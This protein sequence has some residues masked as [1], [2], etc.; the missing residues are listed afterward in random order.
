MFTYFIP[1]T[2]NLTKNSKLEKVVHELNAL[3][4]LSGSSMG[5]LRELVTV[6]GISHNFLIRTY[7][8]LLTCFQFPRSLVQNLL[9][10]KLL[11]S[12]SQN[13]KVAISS[14]TQPIQGFVMKYK[15]M[16]DTKTKHP[17][18]HCSVCFP[19]PEDNNANMRM[20]IFSN[21][22]LI[23]LLHG[24]VD[25]FVDATFTP[26]TPIHSSSA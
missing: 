4:K 18:L 3:W 13:L 25:I 17:F 10:S 5:A 15:L 16:T 11:R 24:I 6:A 12:Y 19:H 22:T 1:L 21:P 7:W 20:M 8:L 9:P 2:V 23:G 26:C 14:L